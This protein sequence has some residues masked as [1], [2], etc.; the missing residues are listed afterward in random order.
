MVVDGPTRR[1]GPETSEPVFWY[2][3]AMVLSKSNGR[4]STRSGSAGKQLTATYHTRVSEYAGTDREAGDA[5]LSAYGKLYGRVERKLFAELAAGRSA[6]SLKSEYL[7]RYQ[8]PAR[9]FNGVRVSLEGKVASVKGHQKLRL[10][11]LGRTNC[12]GRGTDCRCGRAW[13]LGSG[14]P[15]EAASC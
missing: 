15:E 12:T 14:P 7:K 8:I 3:V 1:P 4:S 11:S 6:V 9:M 2:A 10:D 5:A 13:A